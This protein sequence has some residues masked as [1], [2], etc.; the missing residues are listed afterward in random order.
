MPAIWVINPLCMSRG[1]GLI[2]TVIMWDMNGTSGA[3]TKGVV[4][5]K[6]EQ[7]SSRFF[8]SQYC[9]FSQFIV[10]FVNIFFLYQH[11]NLPDVCVQ[12]RCVFPSFFHTL[13]SASVCL[14]LS[15]HLITVSSPPAEFNEIMIDSS[16]GI[17][18]VWCEIELKTANL[19]ILLDD[20]RYYYYYYYSYYHIYAGY[21]QLPT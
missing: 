6:S 11:Q 10:F 13:T 20:H 15:S 21:L 4:R 5:E 19:F 12:N 16:L 2:R 9:H 1:W 18:F 8:F 7:N 14:V 3:I 17:R